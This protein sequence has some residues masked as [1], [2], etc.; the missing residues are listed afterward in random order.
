MKSIQEKNYTISLIRF[1][2][3]LS[4]ITCHILQGLNLE[5]AF[6]FNIGV[7]IFLFM[8]GFLYGQKQIN[9]PKHWFI[10]Q[11]KKIYIP[12]VILAVII[13]LIDYIFFNIKYSKTTI[14]VNLLGLQGFINI[15]P[16]ISHTWFISYILLCYFIT[17]ILQSIK[18]NIM[19]KKI[20]F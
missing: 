9:N 20:L 13:I 2:S 8:S 11:F 15:I 1:L 7:Q 17:P 5:A 6:W 12:Y 16:T 10:K 4:I 3:L 19:E 18:F 14:I